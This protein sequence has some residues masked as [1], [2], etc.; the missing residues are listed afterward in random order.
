M[1]K[2]DALSLGILWDRVVSIA[3]EILSTLVRTSFSII[4]RESYDLAVIIFDADGNPIAQGSASVPSFTGTAGP[5]IKHMFRKFPP[6][7][8]QEGDVVATNDPW[9]GT[10]HLFDINVMRPVFR[11]GKRIGFTMSITHLPDIG[12]AGVSSTATEIYEEG[13]R[14]PV[15]KLMSAGKINAELFELIETNVRVSRQVLGDIMAN[16][17]C[18]EVGGR[19][20]CEFM[21]EYGLDDLT[22]LSAAIRDQSE[23]MLR[24]RIR[25]IPDGVY[26]NSNHSE[27]A[28][29]PIKLAC[30]IDK[31]GD[32]LAFDFT[33]TGDSIRA[34]LNVPLCYTRAWVAYAV[35]C[36]L[37]PDIPNNEGQIRPLDITAPPGCALNTQPPSPT[38]GRHAVGHFVVPLIFG[39]LK[40]VLPLQTQADGAMAHT[41][42]VRGH[43]P[44]GHTIASLYFLAGG[45]GGM[46]GRDGVSVTPQPSNMGVVPSEMW[47]NAMGVTVV[48]R[49]IRPDSGGPGKFRGGLGQEV[50]WRN[51]TGHILIVSF[52][53]QRTDFPALGFDGGGSGAPR[54]IEINGEKARTGRYVL[55]PGDI[56]VLREAGGGGFGNPHERD[57][58]AV[59]EDFRNGF[60]T[61]EAALRDYGV[62]I[63][64]GRA[65]RTGPNS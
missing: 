20:L 56:L 11:N 47:E 16:I 15:C 21:D 63:T 24:E 57:I 31:K 19:L 58:D 17:S 10:G 60:V 7:T 40:D 41:F 22:E 37:C 26:R 28:D 48:K 34:G 1:N 59:V 33:G 29:A 12:G 5:T 43:H 14:L 38:A 45:F 23:A 35:K 50:I 53:A 13:L 30:T 42:S 9:M 64:D 6:D 36:L 61:L 32:S 62:I 3:D 18:N 52:L 25:A 8:L 51:D 2:L 46:A 27:G 39:A 65:Y 54:E 55:Q 4:V 44:K 49:E